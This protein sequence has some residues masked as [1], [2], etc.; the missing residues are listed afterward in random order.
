M[1]S[2][3]IEDGGRIAM[4]QALLSLF[5]AVIVAASAS[6]AFA[7][8]YRTDGFVGPGAGGSMST[9][10]DRTIQTEGGG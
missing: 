9:P 7:Q 1:R 6:A 5:L 2:R 10:F 8:Q 4:K 3:L